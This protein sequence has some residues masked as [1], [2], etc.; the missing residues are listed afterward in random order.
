MAWTVIFIETPSLMLETMYDPFCYRPL[1]LAYVWLMQLSL[2]IYYILYVCCV[3][4]LKVMSP[5]MV[6][7]FFEGIISIVILHTCYNMQ[8]IGE[9]R[10]AEYW[11][12]LY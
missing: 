3:F 7:C 11:I 1:R 4:D 9:R 8:T 10:A 2:G 6:I 12:D 5:W